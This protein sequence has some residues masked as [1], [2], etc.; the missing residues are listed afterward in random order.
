MG[1]LAFWSRLASYPATRIVYLIR[2]ALTL[3]G[4]STSCT[5]AK[6]RLQ[7]FR[8]LRAGAEL[9]AHAFFLEKLEASSI[10]CMK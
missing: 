10:A 3:G 4:V 1:W 5:S 2:S 8:A 9:E 6:D 7:E